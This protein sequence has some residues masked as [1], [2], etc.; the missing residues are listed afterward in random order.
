MYSLNRN[1]VAVLPVLLSGSL[2][3]AQLLL[4]LQRNS[5]K[6]W[7]RGQFSVVQI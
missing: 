4:Q 2:G 3:I 7:A 6:G 1:K 5:R